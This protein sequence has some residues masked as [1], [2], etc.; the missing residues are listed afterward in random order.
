MLKRIIRHLKAKWYRYLLEIVV[1]ILGILI[2][3][4][5]EQWS[6]TRNNSKKEI[7]MLKEF[8]R[9]LSADLEDMH[10]NMSLHD[11]SIRSSKIILQVIN[12][13]LP[14]HD[15][16]DACFAYTHAFTVFSG[17]VGPIEQLK[18]TNLAL[19]SND[20]LRLKIIAMYD[21]AYPR[22]RLVEL[23]IRRDYEQLRDFDRLYFDAYDFDRAS[24]SRSV[25]APPWG[26]MRPLRF[27]ELKKSPEYAA[28]LRARMS[29]Q[30]GL[31]RVHYF[32]IEESLTTLLKQID[33]EIARLE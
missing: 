7:E 1:V 17:R 24:T 11:Y 32:E 26:V 25:P 21:E 16:L 9:G 15:S 20:T 29:N 6:D 3:Y 4:N 12:D 33:Q 19:V 5:L 31:L 8:R 14:Y 27:N 18:N 10:F 28:L 13:D 22:I 2:A 23:A 30:M